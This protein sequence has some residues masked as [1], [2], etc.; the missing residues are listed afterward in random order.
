MDDNARGG[1]FFIVSNNYLYGEYDILI[2]IVTF[3]VYETICMVN[4]VNRN[5]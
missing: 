2:L 5:D 1:A 3:G 4:I